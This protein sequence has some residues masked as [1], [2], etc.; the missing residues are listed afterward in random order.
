MEVLPAITGMLSAR[1]GTARLYLATIFP[2]DRKRGVISKLR[3]LVHVF[4]DDDVCGVSLVT[5][6]LFCCH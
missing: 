2:F 1:V 5:V 6:F 3:Y 4:H